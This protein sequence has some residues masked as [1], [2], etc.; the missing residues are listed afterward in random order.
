LHCRSIPLDP[1]LE[2]PKRFKA[3]P[4]MASR[5]LGGQAAI[6]L[7]RLVNGDVLFDLGRRNLGFISVRIVLDESCASV[8]DFPGVG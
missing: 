2:L 5:L 3:Q 6:M 8:R 1:A 4:L 7:H